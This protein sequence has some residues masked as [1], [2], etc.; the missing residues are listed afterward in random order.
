VFLNLTICALIVFGGLGFPVV[1]EVYGKLR[2][3]DGRRIRFSVHTKTAAITT[4]V[5]IPLGMAAFLYTDM[6]H[7]GAGNVKEMILTSLFQSVTCRTAGFNTVDIGALNSGA[8][9]FMMFLMVVG[10]SPGSCGGGVKTTTLALL[11]S[12]S[13]SRI[14]GQVRVNMFRKSIPDE[15]VTRSISV[16]FLSMFLISCF[17][18]L[19]L[20][21]QKGRMDIGQ[22][23]E[24]AAYLF[25]TISAF[26]TVGLST[27]AT[28]T[29]TA[30]GKVYIIVLMLI[31]RLGVVAFSYILT[32]LTPSAEIEFAEE[33]IMIG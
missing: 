7:L 20:V 4:A 33:N 18:F 31:G 1:Y 2:E 17:F 5:L 12:L 26:G 27:G 22:H 9:T 25:E 6:R 15:T 13:W 8:L 19:L 16:V 10:A 28:A 23:G 21:A 24:F 29:L 14:R 11:A 32:G 30:L 3:R